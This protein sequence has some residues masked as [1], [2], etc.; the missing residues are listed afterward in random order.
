MKWH[1]KIKIWKVHKS[2]IEINKIEDLS[3]G[4]GR[5]KPDDII[6]YYFKRY[7]GKWERNV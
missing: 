3:I 4:I 5:Y 7:N 1:L 6:K 2:I